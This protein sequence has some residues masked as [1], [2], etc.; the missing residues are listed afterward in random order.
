MIPSIPVMLMMAIYSGRASMKAHSG[1]QPAKDLV[2][3]ATKM[4]FGKL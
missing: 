2:Y 1:E 4:D 3:G